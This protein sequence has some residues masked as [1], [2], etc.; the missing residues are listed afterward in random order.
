MR[1]Q[2][3]MWELLNTGKQKIIYLGKNEP[4][5]ILN[6][7]TIYKICQLTWWNIP[8]LFNPQT[9]VK[10]LDI[11]PMAIHTMIIPTVLNK[12][13]IN[14]YYKGYILNWLTWYRISSIIMADCML[15][16]LIT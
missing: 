8:K 1:N 10:I 3:N 5:E 15:E 2:I 16:R 4:E 11:M 6:K 12:K 13:S 9:S 7:V 14:I